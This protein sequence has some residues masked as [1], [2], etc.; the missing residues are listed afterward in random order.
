MIAAPAAGEAKVAVAERAGERD[1]ADI[2]GRIEAG[3]DGFQHGERARDLAGLMLQPFLIVRLGLSPARFEQPL[4][5]CAQF[6]WEHLG[7]E[8]GVILPA[9]RRY[10]SDADWQDIGVTLGIAAP[11]TSAEPDT[12]KPGSSRA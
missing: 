10:L 7:R 6:I 1:L 2:G 8:E 9:A 4:R 5:A 12:G 11:A 3:R